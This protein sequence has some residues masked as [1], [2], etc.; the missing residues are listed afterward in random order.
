MAITGNTGKVKIIHNLEK[1]SDQ[2]KKIKILDIGCGN[3]DLWLDTKINFSNFEIHG[4]DRNSESLSL[5][6]ERARDLQAEKSFHFYN[7]KIQN[8][9]KL[10]DFKFDL[11][12]STQVLEHIKDIDDFFS[13]IKKVVNKDSKGF[14]TCDSAY[15]QQK[16][17]DNTK[18][19]R[20][21]RKLKRQ[22]VNDFY[23]RPLT[24]EQILD[25]LRKINIQTYNFEYYCIN[26]LKFIHN[27]VISFER[28]DIFLERWFELESFLN[29]TG[30]MEKI[31]NYC[32]VLYFDIDF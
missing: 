1:I 17:S 22:Y 31:R 28:K 20:F 7:E 29:N 14:F 23:L 21:V 27:H 9:D 26:P 24:K 3:L 30:E 2:N 16:S 25:V 11:I 15:Y 5:A 19:I 10:F 4:I 32:S 6:K 8:L 13:N 12:V 18:G